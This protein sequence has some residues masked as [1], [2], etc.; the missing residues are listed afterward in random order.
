MRTNPFPGFHLQTT[1][2]R[3]GQHYRVSTTFT[4]DHGLETM[5]F[6]ST[7]EGE[8][9]SWRDLYADRYDSLPEA[10]AGHK[11]TCI[12]FDPGS[13]YARMMAG[14]PSHEEEVAG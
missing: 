1:I 9:T 12:E 2:E 6:A 13:S 7:S 4:P 14:L 3:G 11:Q 5:V 8:V 10:E